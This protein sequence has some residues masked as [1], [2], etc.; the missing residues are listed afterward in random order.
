MKTLVLADSSFC[1]RAGREFGDPFGFFTLYS[2]SHEFATCGMVMVEVLRGVKDLGV[3]EAWRKEFHSLI[4][5]PTSESTWDVARKIAWSLERAGQRL[6]T[7]DIVIAACAREAG[8]AVLTLDKRF[9]E[10]PGL[11]VISGL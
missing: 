9:A 8:A 6:G 10:I 11:R 1:I 7:P 5:L 4:Y 3:M 2:N